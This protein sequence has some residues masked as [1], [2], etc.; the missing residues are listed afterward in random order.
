[1][2]LPLVFLDAAVIEE[3]PIPLWRRIFAAVGW[4]A[5]L[6]DK[7]DSFTHED[8][9][10]ALQR[11]DLSDE[12]LL[13]L[14]T[15]HTLGTGAG[16]DAITSA[17]T[18]RRAE[19]TLLPAG[20]GDREFALH[21]FL[22]QRENAVAAEVFARAQTQVQEG[23]DH[24]RYNEFLGKEARGPSSLGRRVETFNEYMLAYCREK[25]LGDHVQVRAFEDDGVYIIHVIRSDHIKKP[26]AV[27]PGHS[28][29]AT[30]AY[31]PVH[32]DILR[33][34]STVGRLRIAAR[35]P[36]MV[37]VYRRAAGELLFDD[38]HFFTGDPVCT[39]TV[40]QERG[41]AALSDHS[42]PGVGRVW[43]TECLWER[44]DRDLLHIRSNDCFR[45]I[46]ELHLPLRE[47]QLL[48]V[49]LKL[50]V[51]GTSAR[52]V[53]VTIRVPS[54]IEVTQK[55]HEQLVDQFLTSIGIRSR[56]RQ[57]SASDLWSL[58]PW[59][60]AVPVWR[61]L[62]G[63]TTDELVMNGV[64]ARVQ[65]Q[66]V[67]SGDHPGAGNVLDAHSISRGEY[68][69]VSRMPE[70][71]SE[72][73]SAT[74]VEGLELHPERLREYLRSKLL[75][76]DAVP[77]WD[78]GDLLDLGTLAVGG[79]IVRLFYALRE[80]APRAGEQMRT[81]AAGAHHVL[82]VPTSRDDGSELAKLVLGEPI[83]SR[84]RVIRETVAL[85]NLAG[86]VPALFTAP[87][88]AR[89][90][91][92][93][94][95]GRVWMDGAEV[96]ALRAGTHPFRFVE[97][98]ARRCPGRVSSEEVRACLSE[99]RDD[100]DT[101]VRQAKTAAR[102]AIKAAMA[103]SGQSFVEDPFPAGPVGFYRCAIQ[104]YVV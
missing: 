47:G 32:A 48:Q 51:V 83:P 31:R 19:T 26:L 104:S 67:P 4:P 69:G 14:E 71:R 89:L 94:Q 17:M 90:V 77:A 52:P 93:S 13:A 15:L 9:L 11:D 36:S 58:H 59:R 64:L 72:S 25:D 44:G 95:L 91:V 101:A 103:A 6:A 56:R 66:S 81:R 96:S 24:R 102:R 74:D 57:S 35:S 86:S 50:E 27:L 12:L 73:L 43:M 10:R 42:V 28:A 99:A 49:K 75:L 39:L 78:G 34:D 20:A 85:L 62:F 80:P 98:L 76:T 23:A 61:A 7:E 46:E 55:I 38:E 3:V 8:L 2:Q 5:T 22:A 68:Y 37:E 33:Y 65:L 53:T 54:R 70:V 21:L 41:R 63:S 40:L 87:D 16:R 79:H 18:D 29:R 1:M 60:H 84:T 97:M 100:G 82:L 92:D 88:N 30:I 45:N